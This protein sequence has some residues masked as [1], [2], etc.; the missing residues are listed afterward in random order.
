MRTILVAAEL[1]FTSKLGV[2]PSQSSLN[3]HFHFNFNFKGTTKKITF[4]SF[5]LNYRDIS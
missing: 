3:L 4:F 1:L 2:T 5:P